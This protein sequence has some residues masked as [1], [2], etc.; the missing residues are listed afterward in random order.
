MACYRPGDRHNRKS[1]RS[2]EKSDGR[3]RAYD[4]DEL[5]AR[6]KVSLD[7]FWLRDESLADSA[8]LPDPHILAAEIADDLRAALEQIEEVLGDL[9]ERAHSER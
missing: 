5:I 7:I 4:Y 2:E 8:S 6:D 3:W 1:T 9:R